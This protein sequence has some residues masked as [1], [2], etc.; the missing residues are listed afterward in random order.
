MGMS[1][2]GEN[3]NETT[4]ITVLFKNT[5]AALPGGKTTLLHV[6]QAKWGNIQITTG[7]YR[8]TVCYKRNH[9]FLMKEEKW[10]ATPIGANKGRKNNIYLFI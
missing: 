6:T 5:F 2:K 9:Y 3:Q 1:W 10:R 8:I 4:K 7:Y